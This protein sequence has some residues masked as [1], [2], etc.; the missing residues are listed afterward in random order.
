MKTFSVQSKH[1]GVQL[2]PERVHW[3]QTPFWVKMTQKSVN[4]TR[5]MAQSWVNLTL[6]FVKAP[7][8]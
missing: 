3:G 1:I 6:L 4:L 8:S 5:N 2:D 7:E